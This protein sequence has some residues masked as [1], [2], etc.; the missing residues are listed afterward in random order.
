[1]KV[2]LQGELV[3]AYLLLRLRQEAANAS[4]RRR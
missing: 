3:L 2:L 1:M 4:R